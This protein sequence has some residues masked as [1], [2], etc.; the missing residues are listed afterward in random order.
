[1]ILALTSHKNGPKY[2]T[3]I[4]LHF[5][6]ATNVMDFISL[7]MYLEILDVIE[8]IGGTCYSRVRG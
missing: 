6:L 5:L 3:S 4:E 8:T 7:L 2:L 1:M